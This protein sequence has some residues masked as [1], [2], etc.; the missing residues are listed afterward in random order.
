MWLY[1]GSE[2]KLEDFNPVPTGFVYLIENLSNNKKYI[3]KKLLTKAATKTVKGK[4]KKLRIE[5]DWQSYYGS[6]KPLQEDVLALGEDSFRR[7]ILELCYS[8]GHC[9]YT[10]TKLIFETDAILRPEFYNSW[11]SCK[12]QSSHIKHLL[13]EG[14][15]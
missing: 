7:T 14:T 9:S 3:G 8:R 13:L 15:T 2:F 12:I 4:K 11:V 5:S 6:N 10:E 1:N